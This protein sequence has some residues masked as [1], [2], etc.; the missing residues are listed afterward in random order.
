M[1]FVLSTGLLLLWTSCTKAVFFHHERENVRI[2]PDRSVYAL[3]A[4]EYHFYSGTQEPIRANSDNQGNFEGELLF[5]TYRVIATNTAAATGG[6]VVFSMDSYESATVSVESYD[7]ASRSQL[8]TLN[9]Q[10]STVYSVVVPEL[11][12]KLDIQ[13]Y[14]PTPALL[15]KQLKL[16]FMLSGGLET[17]V[18]TITGILP[19]IYFSVYLSTGL[20]TSEAT[21]QSPTTVVRFGIAGQGDER[22]AQ[23]FLLGLRHPEYGAVYTNRLELTLGMNDG[24]EAPVSIDLTDE[25]SDLLSQYQGVLP[26]ESFVEIRLEKTP[27]GGVDGSIGGSISKWTVVSGEEKVAI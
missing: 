24:S 1:G 16:I 10:L 4:L 22:E 23:L 8:S 13:P 9:S 7:A 14:R 15:T 25:L 6:N 17:E 19:G 5:D 18:K 20:P 21:T 26:A 12:V 11:A 27:V 2:Y 3:P